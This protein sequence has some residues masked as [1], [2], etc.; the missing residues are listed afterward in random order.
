MVDQ[1]TMPQNNLRFFGNLTLHKIHKA[2]VTL[3]SNGGGVWLKHNDS[4]KILKISIQKAL[5]R[6]GEEG[7]GQKKSKFSVTQ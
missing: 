1:P 5:R 6:D 3:H 2:A 4:Y 7:F